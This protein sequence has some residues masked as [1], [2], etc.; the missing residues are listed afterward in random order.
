[1]TTTYTVKVKQNGL[2]RSLDLRVYPA[3][4]V[5]NGRFVDGPEFGCSRTYVVASDV[6]AIRQ[7]CA[8]SGLQFVS[9]K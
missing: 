8:D 1:M 2:Q 4:G 5:A 9:A 6:D 3:A 7:A